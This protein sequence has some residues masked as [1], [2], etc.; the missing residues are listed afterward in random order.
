M[1]DEQID[2][3]KLLKFLKENNGL[4]RKI[5]IATLVDELFPNGMSFDESQYKLRWLYRLIANMEN[6]KLVKDVDFPSPNGSAYTWEIKKNIQ[7]EL[8]TAGD[9]YLNEKMHREAEFEVNKLAIDG[10]E[11]TQ[12]VHKSVIDTNR[13]MLD[14]ARD[15]A[16]TNSIVAHNST[17]QTGILD[18]QKCAFEVGVQRAVPVLG[19]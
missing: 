18:R 14:I 12:M 17:I 13:K 6:D 7:M 4:H 5:S 10:Y 3:S 19:R 15:Q 8:T 11:L 16:D 1:E 9:N 2:S